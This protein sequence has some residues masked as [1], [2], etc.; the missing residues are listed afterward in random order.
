MIEWEDKALILS[1]KPYGNTD[2][3]VQILTRAQGK[4]A[5]LLKGGQATRRQPSLQ[6]G[7][8][9]IA[10]W[11]ARL[12]EQLGTLEFE[13][14]DQIAARVLDDRARLTALQSFAVLAS[15]TLSEREPTPELFMAVEVFLSYF[16]E[17]FWAYLYVKLEL[18]LLATL[19]F[20]VDFQTCA[21]GGDA[22]NLTHVS[23]KTGHAVS[24]D[25]AK[26]YVPKL[27]PLPQFLGGADALEDEIGAGLA[28][29]AKLLTR[30]VFDILNQDLP[31][32]RHR[33]ADLFLS[34]RSDKY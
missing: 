10:R 25:L 34:A 32:P 28:L 21:L 31:A 6:P 16:Q 14:E 27:L 1:A 29:T 33:L 9:G 19:G 15:Q 18:S 22:S 24:R 4:T 3:I 26:A 23:P 8:L 13:A 5:G 11:R 2:A 12:E 30:H 20:R 7:T 17:N